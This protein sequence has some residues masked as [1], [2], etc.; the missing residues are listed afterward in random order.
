MIIEDSSII[1][2]GGANGF[3]R[4]LAL[5][6]SKKCQ[7]V[8]VLDIDKDALAGLNEENIST[9]FCDLTD[10]EQVGRVMDTLFAEEV[11]P[12]VLINNA[13]VIFSAPLINLLDR[14]NIA[15]DPQKWDQ[16]LS[17]N[18]SSSFYAGSTFAAKMVKSRTSG[19]ILNI[20]SISAKGNAGQSVYS[21]AKAGVSALTTTWAKEL[22]PFKMRCAAIAPGFFDTPSTQKALSEAHI[23]KWKKSIPVGRL[24]KLQEMVSAVAFIIENDY[25]N[26]KV[27]ELD[28]GLTI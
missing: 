4:E 10:V 5:H 13:G 25:F 21:A 8:F 19:L 12:N 1:I 14:N 20:S 16:M 7:K 23:E 27:L 6:L 2:T 9:H 22:G 24:G 28:G 15:H 3:G 26:G 18:L 17:V 11:S